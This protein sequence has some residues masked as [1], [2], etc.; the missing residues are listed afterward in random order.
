MLSPIG[1]IPELYNFNGDK[2]HIDDITGYLNKDPSGEIILD[3]NP[4]FDKNKQKVN[5]KGYLVDNKGNIINKQGNVI[6]Y[7][8]NL[9]ADGEP[10]KIFPHTLFDID[11]IKGNV[12]LDQKGNPKLTQSKTGPLKDKDGNNVNPRGYLTDQKGNVI[13]RN[14]HWVIWKEDLDTNGEIP[15]VYRENLHKRDDLSDL[16]DEIEK[17]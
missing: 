8:Q 7:K 6:W 3:G 5:Q 12:D 15:R 13:D 14:G 9:N 11:R 1:D 17:D 2:Y 16:M 4:P 10:P